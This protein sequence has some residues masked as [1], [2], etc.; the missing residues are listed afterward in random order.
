[1]EERTEDHACATLKAQWKR[2]WQ[3]PISFHDLKK[4]QAINWKQKGNFPILIKGVYENS[5]THLMWKT[6]HLSI[7][8][9]RV[10]GRTGR[11]YPMRVCTPVSQALRGTGRRI[12]G[13]GQPGLQSDFRT[14]QG[15][16]PHHFY[17]VQDW[18]DDSGNYRKKRNQKHPDGKIKIK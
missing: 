7:K 15:C 4:K 2:I 13:W 3:N 6:E 8:K 16:P 5:M 12:R 10:E 9:K 18:E 14:R 11:D 1:M 17:L